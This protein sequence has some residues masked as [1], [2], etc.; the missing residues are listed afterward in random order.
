MDSVFFER[1]LNAIAARDPRLCARLRT[2]RANGNR[3]RIIETRSGQTIPAI[4]G[5]SG[6][7]YPLHSTIDPQQEARRLISS[8]EE[9]NGNIAAGFLIFLGLGAGFAAQAA[10]QRGDI[11]QVL[12][13]DYDIDGA[14]E[15]FRHFDYTAILSDPRL[16][17][18]IDP[19]PGEIEAFIAENYL[20]ALSGGIR[21]L[22]LRPR[23]AR[24]TPRFNAAAD[25][26]QRTIETISSDYSAQAHF[27]KR[28]FSNIIRN[29][30]AAEN[31]NTENRV[32]IPSQTSEAAVCAAGPSLDEQIPLLAERKRQNAQLFI[33]AAD[34]S[35]PALLSRGLKP[36]AV[37]SIDCQHISYYHFLGINCRDIPLFLDLASPPALARFSDFPV[38][39]S[40]GHPL[41]RYVSQAWRH[42][43]HIDTSGG[44][45][46]YA[47][48]DLAESLGARKIHVYGADFSYPRGRVYARGTYIYPFFEKKQNRFAALEAQFSSFLYRGPF[49]ETDEKNMS[50]RK[51]YRETA[52]L[53]FYRKKFEEK[54]A[55]MQAQ[56][57]VEP[58]LG[59]AVELRQRTTDNSWNKAE[60]FE[61]F[62]PT[63]SALS[64]KDFLK[65]YRKKIETLPV[66]T[67]QPG[68]Y[69]RNLPPSEKQVLAT[70]LPL[71]AALKHHHPELRPDEL[72]TTVKEHSAK[73]INEQLSSS[74]EQYL[75]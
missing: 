59:A 35:L 55:V 48:V 72:L 22:P 58:G 9:S 68:I 31:T 6:A 30:L 18:L 74:S 25:A 57:S 40:G 39:L 54:A 13:I 42:F 17:L 36:D 51:N 28:W 53:R 10:L 45:V 37:V 2:A 20:P 19:P 1:N 46:T 61:G 60:L 49:L 73:Q 50:H 15:L 41:T 52:A 26:I 47:C 24:D 4:T 63:Q 64:A 66:P 43:P 32:T 14:A 27:G 71:A 75:A 65:Q 34:T 56:V 3:Y 33:I 5:D 12:I 70:L 8:L 7:A 69:P 44:N 67:L 29:V 38:F 62:T 23:T 21:V 16:S 11:F